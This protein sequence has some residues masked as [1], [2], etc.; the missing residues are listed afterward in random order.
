MPEFP[1]VDA[2]VH[3]YD[4]AAIPFPWME[5]VPQLNRA[6]LPADFDRLTR[7]V[8]VEAMVFVEVDAAPGRHLDEA[9]WVAKLAT[10]E[11]RLRGMVASIPLEKGAASAADLDAYAGLPIARGVR[12]LIERHADEP[13]WC[14]QPPFIEGVRLLPRYGFTFDLCLFHPQ[15][16]EVTEL[17]RRCPDVRFVIDHIAKPGIRAAMTEPWRSQMREI[18]RLPN[19][20]CKI[21]GVV[22][23]ADHATWREADVAPYVA[24]A[25]ECF[26]FDRVMFGGDWPV[27]ELATTYRRWVDLVDSVIAGASAGERRRLYRDNA[28]AFYRL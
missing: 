9:R 6:Y 16:A 4:P 22:T 10:G 26:G 20:A 3:L 24:H 21:S 2:H 28:I 17:C 1:I 12:R 27:S 14:L 5:K 11:P 18:A 19:V 13:G 8:D 25:I 15:L 23:E 7:G